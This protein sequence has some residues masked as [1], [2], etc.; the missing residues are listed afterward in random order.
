MSD[1]HTWETLIEI[2]RTILKIGL[3]VMDWLTGFDLR[4]RNFIWNQIGFGIIVK[5]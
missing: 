2:I 5:A 1:R 4:I 3:E